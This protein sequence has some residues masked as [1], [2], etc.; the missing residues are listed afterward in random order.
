MIVR[1]CPE[2]GSVGS[3]APTT[4]EMDMTVAPF[5]ET[6]AVTLEPGSK[7]FTG[8]K[9]FAATSIGS[10][11]TPL[12]DTVSDGDGGLTSNVNSP[13]FFGN[14]R[15]SRPA[16]MDVSLSTSIHGQCS[17][18]RP[19]TVTFKSNA[20][21]WYAPQQKESGYHAMKTMASS[22]SDM[23]N[24]GFGSHVSAADWSILTV[25]ARMTASFQP[26]FRPT[27]FSEPPPLS[28]ASACTSKRSSRAPGPKGCDMRVLSMSAL[29]S[30]LARA[31]PTTP[32][33]IH[34]HR[35]STPVTGEGEDAS[36]SLKSP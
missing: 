30:G 10:V 25:A 14:P 29:V 21:S 9:S 20:A 8:S 13:I 19:S 15:I 7:D 18:L 32:C 33:P 16:I 17:A 2:L 23:F 36:L 27:F 3:R 31:A 12:S 34:G 26:N 22:T 35:S 5:L 4:P 1:T 24:T 11:P 6:L 28:A